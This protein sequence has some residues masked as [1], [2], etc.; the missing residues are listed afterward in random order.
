M[1]SKIR[2]YIYS[3]K[4]YLQVILFAC[5]IIGLTVNQLSRASAQTTTAITI[6][7]TK[8]GPV[9]MGA[10]AIIGGGG[11]ARLLIDYPE[12]QRS[13]ILD[14][15]FKPGYG[16][17]LESLK[18]EIGGDTNS[19][20]GS[21][22]SIEHSKGQIDCNSGYE[23]W[24]AEQALARNP[25]IKL[26]ALQWGAPGWVGNTNGQ[27]WTNND[28]KY[29]IDWLNCAKSHGLS[30]SYLGGWNE[31]GYNASWYEN[32]R[33][34]LNSNGYSNVQIIADD[35]N[36]WNI[37][38]ALS[39]DTTFKSVVGVVGIHDQCGPNSEGY[40]CT[41][42][43]TA[44]SLGK[45]LFTSELGRLSNND[46][47]S[48]VRSM[49][50]DYNQASIIGVLVWPM[51]DSMVPGLR[52]EDRGLITADQ[53]W[54]GNYI[55][56]R[57]LWGMAQTTQFAPLGW[58]FVG[59]AN[60]AIGNSGA[61]NTFQAPDHS[62]WS[63]VTENT[64]TSS[65]QAVTVQTIKVSILGGLPSSTV[66]A[67][68]TNVW[69]NDPSQWFV[70]QADIHP[71]NGTFT[72]TLPA[73]SVVT[74]TTT[75]GQS[76]GN[77]TSPAVGSMQLPYIA[78]SDDSNEAWGLSAMDGAFIYQPCQGGHIGNCLEQM[79]PQEP[80]WWSTSTGKPRHPYAI[81][82]DSNWSNYTVSSDVM[83]ANS[84]ASAG[85]IGRFSKQNSGADNEQFDGYEFAA[86]ADGSWHLY[87]NSAASGRVTLKSGNLVQFVPGTWHTMSLSMQGSILTAGIDGQVVT[88][89]TDTTH[90]SG[91]AGILCNWNTDQFDNFQVN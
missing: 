75:T 76:K 70:Q 32:M 56:N 68:T 26:Y 34:N 67:W 62:A 89:T 86:G 90:T 55:V 41:T 66:H 12:P 13:Q 88:T 42:P 24:I 77:A 2:N 50:N 65:T 51:V 25:N 48:L 7:G 22:P 17:N 91:L 46:A 80:I 30:I 71:T 36:N 21:E 79:A 40:T 27:L 39:S 18:L 82:G 74:F 45:P 85:V 14:Y 11:N 72:Y 87:N 78:S 35:N 43:S 29:V 59:G 23:W 37:A 16:A 1:K 6:D 31:R 60:K 52:Y 63:L 58:Q 28:N 47:A 49:I 61:Y 54:S 69:S 44:R 4:P 53:P 57:T 20:D 33:S 64:G 9:F 84:A 38:S 83:F 81:V 3:A 5:I 10:G 73:G 15:L 19:S 8:S